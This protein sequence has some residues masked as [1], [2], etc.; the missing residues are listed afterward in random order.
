MSE[1]TL[2]K[3]SL[4]SKQSVK[5]SPPDSFFGK[6]T[7]CLVTGPTKGLGK[8]IS[9]LFAERFPKGSLIILLSRN[10]QQLKEVQSEIKSLE[11]VNAVYA[12]FDQG[13]A[14][15]TTNASM[16]KEC[17]QNAEASVADFDQAVLIN[18]AGTL[19]PLDYAQNLDD[20]EAATE[21]FRINQ[22]GCVTLTATFLKK[23]ASTRWK[24]VVNISSLAAIQPMKSWLLYCMGKWNS[25]NLALMVYTIY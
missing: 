5:P 15:G 1:K 22:A 20:L 17:L 16:L 19:E 25:K 9:L 12:V 18:N 8:S 11:G 2:A 10:E 21:F 3:Q 24:T 7:V 4:Q 6:K 13:K 14:E 23:F